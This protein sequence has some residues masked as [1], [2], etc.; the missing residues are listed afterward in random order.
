MIIDSLLRNDLY[1]FSMF[2]VV[3]RYYSDMEVEITFKCRSDVKVGY[4]LPHVVEEANQLC[5]LRFTPE[6]MLYVKNTLRWLSPSCISFLCRLQ[7]NREQLHISVDPDG[8]LVIKAVGP[9]RDVIWFEVPVL[10]IVEELY[11]EY[12]LHELKKAIGE[13]AFHQ[14]LKQERDNL[15]KKI[16]ALNAIN[17]EFPFRLSEFGLRRRRSAEWQDYVVGRMKERAK[18]FAGTS[19]VYLAM[20]HGVKPSGTMAH[21]IYMGV[22]GDDNTSLRNVQR[23]TW[24]L[25]MK[26]FHG[27][28]GIMLTDIF[29]ANACF[30]DMDWLVAHSFTG[31]R[32][33]SGDPIAWGDKLIARLTEL[34][35]DPKEKVGVWSDCLDV[36]AIREIA[37]HFSGRIK[38]SFGVGTNLVNM[39]PGVKPLSI[40]MK[41]TKANGRAVLK[42]SDDEG[43]GMCPDPALVEYA[44]SLFDFHPVK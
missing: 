21:E 5:Q 19:D 11:M 15:D 10:A 4:L 17:D 41:M 43:K 44:K 12:Q 3:D 23:K 9:W 14:R 35:I 8:Q 32:H 42:L 22:Q 33:D 16:D 1:K 34:G 26:T 31:F 6:E 36:D 20:K 40:V 13:D 37:M 25:W 39:F 7:L 27:D 29:G 18:F 28:N 38:V 30:R 2:D 24:D